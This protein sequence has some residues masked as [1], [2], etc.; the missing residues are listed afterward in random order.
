MFTLL[1]PGVTSLYTFFLC[2]RTFQSSMESNWDYLLVLKI[3]C[4][5]LDQSGTKP[6][7]F[8][9]GYLGFPIHWAVFLFLVGV[10]NGLLHYSLCYDMVGCS[11]LS[12][13]G[14]TTLNCKVLLFGFDR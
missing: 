2:E 12:D 5:I 9:L 4:Q 8:R 10:L 13:F 7:Q 3:L 11:C 6:S 14:L 1:T